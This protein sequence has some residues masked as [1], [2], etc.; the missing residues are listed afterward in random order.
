MIGACLDGYNATIFAYGQSGSGKTYTMMGPESDIK[1]TDD[2]GLIPRCI[3]YLFQKLDESLSQNGGKLQDYMVN[4]ESLQIYKSQV[5]DLL[6]PDSKQKL[7][8]KTNFNTDTVFVQNLKS[9]QIQTVQE[10]FKLLTKTQQNRVV[11]GHSLNE[12]S[13]RSHMLISMKVVQ[14]S[15]D[16]TLKTS[17]LNFGDLAGSEDLTKALGRNPDPERRKEAIAIN[18]SLSALTTAVSYLSRGSK[19]SFRDSP[20]THILKDSLGGN[21]KTIMLVAASPH[22]YNRGETIRTLRFASTAKKVKNKAKINEEKSM[23]GLK[24]KIK[25]LERENG[26]LRRRLKTPTTDIPP[27]SAKKNRNKSKDK[28]TGNSNNITKK[29]KKDSMLSDFTVD[30]KEIDDDDEDDRGSVLIHDDE[31]DEKTKEVAESTKRRGSLELTLNDFNSAEIVEIGDDDDEWGSDTAGDD[32]MDQLAATLK[33]GDEGEMIISGMEEE[34]EDEEELELTE[35][36]Q[37]MR[38]YRDKLDRETDENVELQFQIDAKNMELEMCGNKIAELVEELN[39]NDRDFHDSRTKIVHLQHLLTQYQTAYPSFKPDVSFPL[40]F[41]SGSAANSSVSYS[42]PLNM[43]S[44]KRKSI[45]SM[46]SQLSRSSVDLTAN[47]RFSPLIRDENGP[48]PLLQH[49]LSL[50]QQS[51]SHRMSISALQSAASS[52]SQSVVIPT[53]LLENLLNLQ[54]RMESKMKDT[55][56]ALAEIKQNQHKR[57]SL[58]TTTK[59]VISPIHYEDDFESTINDETNDEHSDRGL[60]SMDSASV[61]GSSA[62]VYESA[63]EKLSEWDLDLSLM[64]SF[65]DTSKL[66]EGV[67]ETKRTS[68]IPPEKSRKRTKSGK[69]SKRSSMTLKSETLGQAQ[70][71]LTTSKELKQHLKALRKNEKTLKRDLEMKLKEEAAMNSGW[72]QCFWL[73]TGSGAQQ[74]KEGLGSGQLMEQYLKMKVR[75]ELVRD[76][77]RRKKKR[78]KRRAMSTHE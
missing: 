58:L 44:S 37:Q 16:G 63:D 76:R 21:S 7:V 64:G 59:S 56:S 25:E 1:H 33:V 61:G 14:R 46:T 30:I 31:E 27:N 43:A 3:I 52:R 42:S 47:G 9:V 15:L 32:A 28:G 45:H 20:L 62:L 55:E 11:K 35:Y 71:T 26:K 12:V 23:S 72:C 60:E 13:S 73:G 67:M 65:S 8:I 68:S 5:L 57:L 24:K 36:V 29:S 39:Q 51:Q 40:Q 17:K 22:I 4:M 2:F 54:Q 18:R 77:Y 6:N 75:K 49:R 48:S 74:E 19:P 69:S 78:G 66:S 50:S 34:E 10:A 53:H 70:E 41:T 38:E